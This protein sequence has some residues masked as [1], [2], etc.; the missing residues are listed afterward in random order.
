MPFK[1]PC[2]VKVTR[3]RVL[4]LDTNDPC[5]FIFSSDH[6][7]I[8]RMITRG[9]GKQANNSWFFDIDIDYNIVMT[10]CNN[11][12]VY[13]FNKEGEEIHRIGKGGQ[14]IGE[15]YYPCGVAIDNTGR[16]VV[17][18]NKDTSCLQIF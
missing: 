5:L 3:D 12:C 18:C 13:I 14:G 6:L 16:V 2:D 4:V 11:D 8:N 17:V 1:G 15:F 7:I 9:G 10:D